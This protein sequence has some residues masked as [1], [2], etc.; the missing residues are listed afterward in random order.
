MGCYLLMYARLFNRHGYC[1]SFI[2]TSPE[3]TGASLVV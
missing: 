2:R 3:F 1:L